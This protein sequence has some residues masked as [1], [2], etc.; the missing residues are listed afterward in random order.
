MKTSV[1]LLFIVISVV[2]LAQNELEDIFSEI[3]RIEENFET[4]NPIWE[5]NHPDVFPVMDV[6]KLLL[7]HKFAC[8]PVGPIG[9]F[10]DRQT[11]HPRKN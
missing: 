11:L 9:I 4:Q 3:D 1:S 6:K 8:S 7:K 2:A 10:G 5:G